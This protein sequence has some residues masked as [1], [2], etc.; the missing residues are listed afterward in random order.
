MIHGYFL[1]SK[2]HYIS[3]IVN[4]KIIKIFFTVV[5]V[6]VWVQNDT[7]APPE[8]W[9]WVQLHPHSPLVAAYASNVELPTH[10]LDKFYKCLIILWLYC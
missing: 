3:I 1:I 5:I 9:S 8:K 2:L 4:N 7:F 10:L 6:C